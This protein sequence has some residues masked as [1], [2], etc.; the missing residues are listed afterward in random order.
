MLA[1]SLAGRLI[2]AASLWSAAA[3]IVAGL[4]LTLLY[5]QTVENAF[6]A[7]LNIYLQSLIGALAAQDGPR[8]VDPGNLGEQRFEGLFSGWYWQVQDPD[9]GELLL[10]SQSLFSDYF[11]V[12]AIAG[13]EDVDGVRSV[14]LTGPLE[15]ALRIRARIITLENGRRLDVLVAGDAGELDAQTRAFGTSVALTLAVFGIGLVLAT[16]IQI[17]WG[18]RPLDRMRRALADLRSGR[19]ARFEGPFPTEIA[20]LAKELNAVLESNQEVIERA[21]TQVGNLAHALKT[22]LSV[23][24]NEARTP[25]T[26]GAM[27][28]VEQAELMR[29]Q[30]DHHLDRARIAA[31]ANVIG[32]VTDVEP[33]VERLARVMRR[34]SQDRAIEVTASVESGLKFRGEQQD[35]EEIIGNLVD[36]ASKWARRTV[37]VQAVGQPGDGPRAE[38]MVTIHVDDDGPGLTDEECRLATVRG[39]RLDETKP[40]SGLGLSIVTDLVGLYGGEFRLMR[41]PSGGLRAEV[42][43]P[44]AG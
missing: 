12:Q 33:V 38:P 10:A 13:L 18:L 6:D 4:I 24:V 22:P 1:R 37:T 28:I 40:G 25:T 29:R 2:I 35:F 16:T 30:I 41:A 42:R 17:R 43:L 5:R 8:P 7:R 31:Q 23:V 9:S 15:Q 3:L 26:A 14:S 21:R 34:L 11:D 27:K 19:Q 44:A 20:P 32:A 39:H 36:N